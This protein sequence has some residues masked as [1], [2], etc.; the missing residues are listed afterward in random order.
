MRF[1][2]DCE[3][4][5]G[6]EITIL[7][8]P[9][10][11][12]ENACR[13]AG[14]RGY[15]NGIGGAACSLRLKRNVRKEWEADQNHTLRYV[16]GMDCAEKHRCERI[17]ETMPAQE[18]VFPLVEE[19][20]TKEDAH[21]IL[22]AS[23]IKRPAM[24]DMGYNNNN[25]IGCVKGGMGYWN[26]IRR[27]FPAVFE[28]RA[29]MERMIKASCIKGVYLDELHPDKGIK[30]RPIVDDCGILCETLALMSGKEDAHE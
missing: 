13:M 26:H 16:W 20:L 6:K 4:W 23:G 5:F 25:C 22:K 10:K 27:D 19:N 30:G 3:T 1:V 12:V 9:Y 17:V 2:L 14:G 29:N 21:R 11:T 8:S 28:S 24:Y 7:Q 15:I 18:H